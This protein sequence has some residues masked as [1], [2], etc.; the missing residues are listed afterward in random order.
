MYKAFQLELGLSMCLLYLW[1]DL[2]SSFM[3]KILLMVFPMVIED[4]GILLVHN[5]I[6]T[7]RKQ[8]TVKGNNNVPDYWKIIQVFKK[9]GNLFAFMSNIP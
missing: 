7:P 8:D 3:V 5:H 9:T 1:S 2:G 4:K 6:Y